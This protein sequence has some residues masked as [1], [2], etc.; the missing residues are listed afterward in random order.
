LQRRRRGVRVP[1][2]ATAYA[3]RQAELMLVTTAAGPK[4]VVAAARPAVEEI[5]ARLAPHVSG[6]YAHFLSSAA[7]EDVAAIYPLQTYQRLAAVKGQYDPGN[8]FARSH[9][10]RPQQALADKKNAGV[11]AGAVM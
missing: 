8:L 5:W 1:E 4:P 10:V 2:D 9:N 3:H 7:E 6:A 11:T